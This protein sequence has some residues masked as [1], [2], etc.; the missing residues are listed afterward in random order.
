MFEP[1]PPPRKN[2]FQSFYSPIHKDVNGPDNGCAMRC[3]WID[4][5][6]HAFHQY[7]CCCSRGKP[8]H[9][10]LVHKS[11]QKR[12]CSQTQ[13]RI[14]DNDFHPPWSRKATTTNLPPR[15]PRPRPLRLPRS[16]S[17]RRRHHRVVTRHLCAS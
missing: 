5:M 1:N 10:F 3:I 8:N 6:F 16:P 15:Q 17:L 14:I 2:R 4:G 7:F 11:K 9:H 13:S 12:N